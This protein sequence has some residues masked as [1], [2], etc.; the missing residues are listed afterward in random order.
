MSSG[1]PGFDPLSVMGITADRTVSLG[2]V[3][4][5][6]RGLRSAQTLAASMPRG[7]SRPIKAQHRSEAFANLRRR[8]FGSLRDGHHG[9]QDFVD[10]FYLFI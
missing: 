7:R 8:I 9:N 1:V 4:G 3:V 2:S 5:V 10:L 6:D